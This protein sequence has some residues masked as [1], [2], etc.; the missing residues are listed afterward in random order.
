M[1]RFRD[2]VGIKEANVELSLYEGCRLVDRRVEKNVWTNVGR[3]YIVKVVHWSTHWALPPPVPEVAYTG[4][5]IGSDEQIVDVASAYP[6]L[7]ADYPGQ[8][9]QDDSDPIIRHLERPVAVKIKGAG[10]PITYNWLVPAVYDQPGSVT[11]P[12]NTTAIYTYTYG[13]NDI[14]LSGQY[15]VVPVSEVCLCLSDEIEDDDPYDLGV[16]PTYFGALRQ[17]VVAYNG[18]ASLA[19]TVKNTLKIKW[20]LRA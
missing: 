5:G 18:F 4:I 13:K 14:N 9:L 1:P 7:D 16:A 19:K 8:N 15:G 12:S 17:V 3:N 11:N 2:D 20:E 10:P 6:G